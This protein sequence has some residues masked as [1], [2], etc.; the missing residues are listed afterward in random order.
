ME[1]ISEGRVDRGVCFRGKDLLFN[2]V[3]K[4]NLNLFK[5]MST[6]FDSDP[7]LNSSILS[8]KEITDYINRGLLIEKDTYSSN[9]L[10]ASSYDLRVGSKGIIGGGEGVEVN[11]IHEKTLEIPLGAYAELFLTKK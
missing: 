7:N 4:F 3:K 1:A 6:L 9:S 8:D 5:I 11:L 10:E 2:Y